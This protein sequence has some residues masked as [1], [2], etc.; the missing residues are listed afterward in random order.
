VRV[1]SHRRGNFGDGPAL[2]RK[3]GRLGH[4][5][6]ELLAQPGVVCSLVLK[7]VYLAFEIEKL[8]G[9]VLKKFLPRPD[10]AQVNDAE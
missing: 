8:A 2:S 4:D 5:Q 3:F 6:V 10:V 7:A 1:V 9:Q